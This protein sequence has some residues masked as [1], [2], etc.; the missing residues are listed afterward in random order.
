MN[1][2]KFS[3][4]NFKELKG[5]SAI[6]AFISLTHFVT[7][8]KKKYLDEQIVKKKVIV[9]ASKIKTKTTTTKSKS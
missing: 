5:N 8:E 6:C 7:S 9:F 2:F 1:R 4:A 3:I